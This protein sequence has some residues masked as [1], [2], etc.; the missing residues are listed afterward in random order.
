M[1]SEVDNLCVD[2]GGWGAVSNWWGGFVTLIGDDKI[3][4]Q[5]EGTFGRLI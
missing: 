4:G 2:I 3:V 1:P 5:T